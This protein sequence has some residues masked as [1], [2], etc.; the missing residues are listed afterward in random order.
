MTADMAHELQSHG[1][2]VVSLYPGLV[3]TEAV[4]AAGVFDLSNSESP[5]FIG[6]AVASL[7]GDPGALRR[8]GSVLVAA[9]LAEEYGFTDVDGRQPR[10]LTLADV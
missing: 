5:E 2:T 8:T 3:R 1:V 4:L 7:A 6:R 9:A 10:P